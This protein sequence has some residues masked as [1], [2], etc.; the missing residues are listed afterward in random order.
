M[1]TIFRK[2]LFLKKLNR[3]KKIM[4]GPIILKSFLHLFILLFL[5][6]CGVQKNTSVVAENANPYNPVAKMELLKQEKGKKIKKMHFLVFG[7]SKGSPYF[8][9]VLKRADSLQP[10]FCLTTADLVNRG[11]GDAG[12]IDYAK[13]DSDGGWFMRK[14]PMWPTVGNHEEGGGTDAI[15]N[16]SNF[17]GMEKAMYAFEYGN[18][19]FIALPW[20]KIKNNPEA[21]S[22]LEDELKTA[23]RKHIFIFM[24]RPD[25]TVGTKTYEDV[26]GAETE[27]TK[28][29]DKYK[30]TA[31][32]SGHD[33]IYYRT[34]RNNTNYII[35]AGA[36]AA[37]YPLDREKDAIKNDVYYGRRISKDIENGAVPYK[38]IAANGTVTDIP[39]AMYYVLSVKIDGKD[40]SIEMIDSKTGKVWDK[41]KIDNK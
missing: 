34:K 27:T 19:K 21:L 31:V 10:D 25:Y 40:I 30:V 38:F 13:L 37:I 11:G 23:N 12:K 32:F 4:R 36:G 1:L 3:E 9:D 20:P 14:Y 24:H 6:A 39:E 18:A 35:S 2:V 15:D 29:Y 8:I 22:W 41:A 26:E 33:H 7:D 16:F 28:L 5:T 17:F